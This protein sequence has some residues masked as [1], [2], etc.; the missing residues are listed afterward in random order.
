[1]MG[2]DFYFRTKIPVVVLGATQTIGITLIKKISHHPWFEV[3]ALCDERCIGQPYK[4]AV[5][6]SASLAE[7]L[8]HLILQPN[9]P[10]LACSLVFSCLHSHYALPTEKSWTEAGCCVV[11][12]REF[13]DD[14]GAILLNAEF[15]VKQGD[16][17]W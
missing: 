9:L 10:T 8:Q 15:L 5:P 7:S 1:M 17:Y 4:E 16:V 6:E 11:S 2:F 3:V 12:S 14:I 13:K